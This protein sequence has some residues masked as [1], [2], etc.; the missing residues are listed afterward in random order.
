MCMLV[1]RSYLG[2]SLLAAFS[3]LLQPRV[4]SLPVP[5]ATDSVSSDESLRN[6]AVSLLE[7]WCRGLYAH[8]TNK[9]GDPSADGGI[10]SPGDQAYPGRCADSIYPFLWM[11]A[12]TNDDKYVNAAKKVYAWEQHN[13]W[14]DDLG[15]WF[16]DPGRPDGWKS[17]TV[18]SAIT[19]L[20]A[21]EQY[22]ELLGPLTVDEWLDR[23]HMAADYIYRTFHVEYA[24]INYPAT[25]TFALHKLGELFNEEK[26][27]HKAA[28][29]AE[30]I[31]NYFTPEGF[32]YGEGGRE[33]NASGQYPVDLG[34]NVEESLPA[35]ARYS[36][37]S[38][39]RALQAL[40]LK[41]MRLH[42][43][44]M[45]PN[46]GWD[47]SWGTRSFKWTLWGSR[48]SDGC[49]PGYYLMA[50][51]EPVFAEAVHRNLKCLEASTYDGLLY[52]GPHEH[53]A[54]VK[55]STHHTFCH[56]KALVA[57]LNMPDPEL[58]N[59]T[60]VLPRE[61]V[62]NV[63]I[64]RDIGTLLFSKGSWRGTITTYNVP[65]KDTINGHCSGGALSCLH[66]AKWGIVSAASM[67]EYQRWE[68]KNML[69][70]DAAEHFMCLTPKLELR[71][72]KSVYRNISDHQAGFEHHVTKEEV[73]VKTRAKLVDCKQNSPASGS[74]CAM[75]RY[76]I[77]RD[78]LTLTVKT[79]KKPDK[80]KLRFI[81]PL[82]CS[83]E[84]K[85]IVGPGTLHIQS[86]R[87]TLEL[88]SNLPI[89][90]TLA[91]DERVFNV[92]PG[93]Q[94]YPVEIDCAELHDKALELKLSFN[95]V[96]MSDNGR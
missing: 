74:P 85:V 82:V 64:Y 40:V 78:A 33:I 12:R 77:G 79:D 16:N 61:K 60:V 69:D 18:F 59:R 63:R 23:L 14:S 15:C 67:T 87:G 24:N 90:T 10:Y 88:E 32:L 66:H 5:S 73:L 92:V 75:L 93:L 44:F 27:I 17:I 26:Y 13:C 20:E 38:Q 89:E 71:A 57:L 84:D 96:S 25:A 91:D 34:Y 55:P 28:V 95:A 39:N 86:C 37:L 11:A 7:R 51:R 1:R 22:A 31:Q 81:F 53:L 21:I 9:P 43:E 4:L 45:L 3:A 30:G 46:G 42:L 70:E 56:A 54:R 83:S 48:T 47:N 50:D 76:R 29:I 8:Q 41:S 6:L 62:Y 52:S 65:S 36:H 58:T 19:K 72:G 94:A 80:G 68:K 49:H 2:T 35:L